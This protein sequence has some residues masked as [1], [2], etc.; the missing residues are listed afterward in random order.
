MI[1]PNDFDGITGYRWGAV[2][3][4]RG[5]VFF[6]DHT[7]DEVRKK[8]IVICKVLSQAPFQ[9]D[10][11]DLIFDL[12]KVLIRQGSFGA[13]VLFC[14]ENVNTSMIDIVLSEQLDSVAA[15]TEAERTPASFDSVDSNLSLV[16]SLDFDTKP[17]PGPVLEELMDIYAHFL[18][19][20]ARMLAKKDFNAAGLSTERLSVKD[21]SRALN[22]LAARLDSASK[23]EN[24]LDQAVLLKTKF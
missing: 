24:F 2:F 22:I 18:G 13:M 7:P 5:D 3:S 9:L 14:E 16:Q 21:W 11:A 19:P 8:V 1:R 4:R 23:R 20:L 6:S 10:S 17:L 12:G 15:K